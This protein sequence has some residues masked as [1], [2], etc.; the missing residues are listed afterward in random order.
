MEIGIFLV[1]KEGQIARRNKGIAGRGRVGTWQDEI[2]FGDE[3]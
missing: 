3:N 1:G 2:S